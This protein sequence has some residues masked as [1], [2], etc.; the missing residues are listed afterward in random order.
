MV[1]R[2][3]SLTNTVVHGGTTRQDNVTVEVLPDVQ[4]ALH[5]R[6]VASLVDTSRL[7]TQE[8]RLEES[9]GTPESL[10]ANG[11][12]LSVG[13]LVRLL[14]LGG[15]GGGLD[16]LLKVQSDVTEL[17]LDVSDDFS[18]GSGGE[19]VTSLHENLD[20]VVGQVSSGKVETQDGVGE[21]ETLVD[22]DSV[23]DTVSRVKDDTSGSTGSVQGQ[24]GLD[25][26]VEGGRVEGLEHDLGHFL[27][28]LLGVDGGLGKEDRVLLGGDSELVVEGVVPDL[29]HVVPVGDDTV[30]NGVLEGEDTSFRLSLVT[31]QGQTPSPAVRALLTRRKSPFDPYRPS[32]LGVGVDR[33]WN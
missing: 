32:H 15:L 11:D 16:L 19:G 24:D 26:D 30:L 28:V 1:A 17:L 6:V 2:P 25:R 3:S 12:D 22:G 9:L 4:V 33:R 20:K 8:G 21:R 18:L 29:L 14:E 23:G 13:K 31:G 5:D 7:E 10:V 27:S